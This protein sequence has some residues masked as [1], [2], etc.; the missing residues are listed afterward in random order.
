MARARHKRP[1]MEAALPT[2]GLVDDNHRRSRKFIFPLFFFFG[3][4]D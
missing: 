2:F 4:Q 1:S 3:C